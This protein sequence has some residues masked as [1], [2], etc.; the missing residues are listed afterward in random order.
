MLFM[1][2]ESMNSKIIDLLKCL[3]SKKCVG[4]RHI[5]ERK[6]IIRLVAHLSRSERRN[7]DREYKH[8]LNQGLIIRMK[9]RTGKGSDWHIS[10]NPK[11]IEEV[12]GLL[13]D[14]GNNEDAYGGFL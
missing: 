9:K 6:V 12:S 2:G 1:K 10:L 7:F 14:G 4:G 13:H 3:L 8:M 11:K 5:P